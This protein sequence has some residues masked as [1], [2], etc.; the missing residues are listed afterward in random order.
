M[1]CFLSQG[2]PNPVKLAHA[3]RI[4][5]RDIARTDIERTVIAGSDIALGDIGGLACAARGR[6]ARRADSIT[7]FAPRS[8]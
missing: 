1:N 3:G 6:M 2:Q 4:A 5:A 7:N 8:G